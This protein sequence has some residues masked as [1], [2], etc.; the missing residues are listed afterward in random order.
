MVIGHLVC[1]KNCHKGCII[2]NSFNTASFQDITNI[3]LLCLFFSIDTNIQ[4]FQGPF[5]HDIFCLGFQR[6]PARYVQ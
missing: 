4:Y 5:L 6:H 3:I 2:I 1:A